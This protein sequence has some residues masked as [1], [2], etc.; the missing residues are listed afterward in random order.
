MADSAASKP[1][2]A[3][4]EHADHAADAALAMNIFALN[5]TVMDLTK[6]LTGQNIRCEFVHHQ[7][8]LL[9]KLSL[10]SQVDQL[11][12][13]IARMR[14]MT[15]QNSGASP[16]SLAQPQFAYPANPDP[17]PVAPKRRRV[18]T[19][20]EGSA[21]FEM[22]ATDRYSAFSAMSLDETL[23]CRPDLE[24]VAAVIYGQSRQEEPKSEKK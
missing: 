5:H 20:P 3:N 22:P 11:G 9:P 10:S 13:L 14:G 15:Q 16:Q 21:V 12:L 24:Q 19:Y 7:L 6:V 17:D 1:A 2:G 8:G 18:A 4:D 23:Q